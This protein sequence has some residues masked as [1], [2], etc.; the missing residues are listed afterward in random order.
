MSS[1]KT[2]KLIANA[3]INLVEQ[4]PMSKISVSDIVQAS[5]KNR[6]TFYYHFR[7][8]NSLII[9][10]FRNNISDELRRNFSEKELVF[11]KDENDPFFGMP[12][13]TFIKEGVRQLDGSGFM[14]TLDTVFLKQQNFYSQALSDSS[15]SGLMSY[16]YKLYTPAIQHDIEFTLS[17]RY[18]PKENIKFLSVFYTGAILSY[19]SRKVR[20]SNKEDFGEIGPFKNIIEDSIIQEIAKQQRSRTF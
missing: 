5:K 11:P 18:L 2:E 8:K 14:K 1:E 6:K 19:Y 10:I 13:Y 7:D 15:P 4:K 3:F 20:A 12:Y 9:W 17:N 16:L